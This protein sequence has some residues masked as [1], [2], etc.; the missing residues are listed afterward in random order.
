MRI[1]YFAWI[2]EHIGLSSEDYSTQAKTVRELID[3]LVNIELRYAKA[4]SDMKSIRA[5]V[6]QELVDDLNESI[7]GA[8]EV[9]FFPPMTGG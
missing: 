9:A 4:F 7:V 5:A 3:E 1:L 8:K 2:R 6:D